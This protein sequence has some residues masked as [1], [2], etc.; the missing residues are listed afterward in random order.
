LDICLL[1]SFGVEEIMAKGL[2]HLQAA[3]MVLQ[4]AGYPLSAQQ[5]V[6]DIQKKQL[7]RI[8]GINPSSTIHA[9]ISEDIVKKGNKSIFKRVNRGVYALRDF[10]IEEYHAQKRQ[11]KISHDSLILVFPHQKLLEIGP[12]QGIRREYQEYLNN[13]LNLETSY[14]INRI[15]A[16]ESIDYKQVV[17]YV[18]IK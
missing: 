5:I 9:R 11:K 8:G 4:E 17:S 18:I 16:E 7:A 13:L 1:H 15:E 6:A 2:T 3:M 14:F 12:F 10:P